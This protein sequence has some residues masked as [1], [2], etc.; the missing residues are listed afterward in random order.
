MSGYFL[1]KEESSL[2]NGAV[3]EVHKH[4]GIGL[5]E[6]VYQDALEVEFKL[7]DIPY[8]R[9][10]RFNINYKGVTLES[11]YIADFVCFDKIIVELK[12]V[13][14]LLDVHKAQVRNYLS[15]TNLELGLLYNFNELYI[16]P[17]RVLNPN[18]I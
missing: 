7:R 2:I 11:F 14:E 5:L 4:L 16:T 15:L 6:K 1:F 18:H 9:E 17:V 12:S 13:T 10:K 8:V 3:F